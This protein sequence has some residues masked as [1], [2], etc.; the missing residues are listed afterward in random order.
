MPVSARVEL[1]STSPQNKRIVTQVLRY[2]WQIH[3]EVM[4]HRMFGRNASS[5]RAIPISKMIAEARSD[6][7]RA[8]PS[9]KTH[10]GP[11]MQGGP[12][13]TEEERKLARQDW[14]DLALMTADWAEKQVEKGRAKQ[15]IN[16]ALMPFT[17][18]NVLVTA[19][20]WDNFY[21][22]RLD[23][24]ADP[25]M[26]ALAIAMWE[27]QK[28]STPTLL[29]PGQWHLPFINEASKIEVAEYCWLKHGMT[30]T[31]FREGR[32][33]EYA[34]KVSVARAARVSYLMF[35]TPE[36]PLGKVSTVEKDLELYDKLMAS[37]PLHASPAEHQATPD[38]VVDEARLIDNSTRYTWSRPDLH[39]NL[40]G[41]IQYRKTLAGEDR[42]PIPEEFLA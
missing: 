27:A 15:D 9:F 10:G 34:Q 41:W 29:Q 18:A 40:R 12:E 28:K 31:S 8:Y 38:T 33:L 35:P 2:P 42:A 39:G 32:G 30:S 17:H 25:T 23:K 20:E 14:R 22:L 26:R 4:T 1:D 11:G 5:N 16:R 3:G 13:M 36:E 37:L 21:G 24:A 19:T 6:D 7:G